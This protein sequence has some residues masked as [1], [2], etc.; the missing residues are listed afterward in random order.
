[1]K[2]FFS[3]ECVIVKEKGGREKGD[4]RKRGKLEYLILDLVES[5][6]F[7]GHM[8]YVLHAQQLYT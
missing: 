4:E 8:L 7:G 6:F 5:T 2:S 1:M 3:P